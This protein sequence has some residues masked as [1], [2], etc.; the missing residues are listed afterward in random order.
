MASIIEY[1]NEQLVKLDKLKQLG[2]NPY[3][4]NSNR[5]TELKDIK[6]DF[7]SKQ[8]QLV[9][10]AGRL[11]SHRQHSKIQFL[12]IES[13]GTVLQ[14][15]AQPGIEADYKN[16]CLGFSDLN[17]LTRGDIIEAEGTVGKSQ[18]GEKSVMAQYVRLLTK[19]LRP[20]P[21]KLDNKEVR[22]RRRYLDM[23]IDP[24]VRERFKRRSVFW[25]ATR[26]FLN[27]HD[28]IEISTPVLEHTT[29]GADARPFVTHM[30][31]LGED[32]YLR[33]SHELPLKRLLGG[34]F[35]KVYD[36]GPRFRN[37]NYS[38]EHLPE[39]MSM[40]WYWA[41]VDWRDGIKLSE[42]MFKAVAYATFGRTTMEWRDKTIDLAGQWSELD[43]AEVIEK[44][45]NIDVF[46]TTIAAINKQL[47]SHGLVVERP[48]VARGI[49]KLWKNIRKDIAGP[50]WLI[51]VPAF[52]SPLSKT[53]PEKPL[54]AERFHAVIAGSELSNGFSELNDPV[55]QLDRFIEQQQ[56]RDKG[57]DE[58]HMLDIDYVEMLEYGMPPACG[59]AYSERF[60]WVFEGL[61]ARE[62]VPFPQLR[63][64]LDATTKQIYPQVYGK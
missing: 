1:R 14:L 33:I 20:L 4:S 31:A 46:N 11:V 48:S 23:A 30:D 27:K 58:A 26:D 13:D 8:N 36:I 55:E 44:H 53:N 59:F 25:Q 60:F 35:D 6:A 9:C 62:C 5:N 50:T 21:D 37:E 63:R 49:D 54:L 52:L 24:E 43:Y 18:N 51:N 39:H 16:S 15:I 41:Y 29:G 2:V 57:D 12:D 3:P 22:L 38:D 40:E 42:E 45:Y 32:F 28:F 56:L 10:V 17:L 19:S 34:G 64:E 47:D 61:S 7:K